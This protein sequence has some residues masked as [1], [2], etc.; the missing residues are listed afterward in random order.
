MIDLRIQ[1]ESEVGHY[2][3]SDVTNDF[4]HM[5]TTVRVSSGWKHDHGSHICIQYLCFL[6]SSWME[7]N[8]W[9]DR[10]SDQGNVLHTASKQVV[11]MVTSKS[12][13]A[14]YQNAFLYITHSWMIKLDLQLVILQLHTESGIAFLNWYSRPFG[15]R[16]L[17]IIQSFSTRAS[18]ED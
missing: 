4:M 12:N 15:E 14:S 7:W 5:S 2:W 9:L 17:V 13:R 11:V 1:Y 10:Q 18:T 6:R 3:Y 8:S 16:T